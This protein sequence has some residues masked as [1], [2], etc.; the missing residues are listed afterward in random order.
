M[1]LFLFLCTVLLPVMMSVIGLL[2]KKYPPKKINFFYGYRTSRSM[3]SQATW[4][5]AHKRFS[6]IWI[7]LG[8]VVALVSG[9]VMFAFKRHCEIAS[10]IML[11]IQIAIILFTIFPVEKALKEN[12]DENGNPKN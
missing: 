11:F 10:E 6:Q 4:D 3:K 1:F 8:F 12:F 2:M 7:P 5:F 9:A